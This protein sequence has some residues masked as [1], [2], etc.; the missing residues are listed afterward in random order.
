MQEYTKY[1]AVLELGRLI[2][3]P[4][5]TLLNIAAA[6]AFKIIEENNSKI[7]VATQTLSYCSIYNKT[8]TFLHSGSL[9]SIPYLSEIGV[10][11]PKSIPFNK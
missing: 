10:Q 1:Q 3:H 5:E 4:E 9:S 7:K 11:I 2:T 8:N 6:T